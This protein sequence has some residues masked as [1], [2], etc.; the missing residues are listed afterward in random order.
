[1]NNLDKVYRSDYRWVLYNDERKIYCISKR[2]PTFKKIKSVHTKRFD[3][4]KDMS[5]FVNK[6]IPRAYSRINNIGEFLRLSRETETTDLIKFFDIHLKLIDEEQKINNDI[7]TNSLIA[8]VDGNH[9]TE[10]GVS[11]SG[12]MLVSS[13]KIEKYVSRTK[14]RDILGLGSL[15]G[16][17]IAAVIAI[18]IALDRHCKNLTIHYDCVAVESLARSQKTHENKLYNMYIRFIQEARQTLNIKFVKVKA[19]SG[20]WGN[21]TADSLARVAVR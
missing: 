18:K 21:C 8:Y 20:D 4:L 2:S 6:N 7:D 14:K 10:K 5:K 11:G 9:F 13:D 19:H 16:E 3:T 17:L 12:V 15:G 1:M